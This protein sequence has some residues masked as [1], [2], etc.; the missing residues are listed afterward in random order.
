MHG[1]V[2]EW[3]LDHWANSNLEEGADKEGAWQSSLRTA[4][5]GSWLYDGRFCRSANRDDYFKSNRCS[6]LGFRVVLAPLK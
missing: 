4:R 1:N 2:W 3:C 5:G 6:D